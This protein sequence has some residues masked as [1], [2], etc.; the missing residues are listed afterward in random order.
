MNARL[1][2]HKS[3]PPT[4]VPAPDSAAPATVP[5][6]EQLIEHFAWAARASRV[7]RSAATHGSAKHR[8]AE[9]S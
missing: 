4:V 7:D 8:G 9:A 5:V 6:A 3:M 2:R 1:R